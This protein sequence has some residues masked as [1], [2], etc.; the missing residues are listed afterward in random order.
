VS[1][2]IQSITL[3]PK[4]SRQ[5]HAWR[6]TIHLLAFLT[7]LSAPLVLW[8]KLL[9]LLTLALYG[10]FSFRQGRRGSGGQIIKVTVTPYGRARMVMGGGQRVMARIRR[11][12]LVTPWLI[13]LRFDLDRA[14]LPHSLVL[15]SDSL[16]EEQLRELRVL[17][18]FGE[19]FS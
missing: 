17:L 4:P 19:L 16:G 1:G 5:L 14:W 10:Y 2:T 18:R 7:T 11:D 6:L 9:L 12:S 3:Q 15:T 8:H 13:V